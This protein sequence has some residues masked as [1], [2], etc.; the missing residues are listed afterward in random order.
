MIPWPSLPPT[1]SLVETVWTV[2][3]AVGTGFAAAGAGITASN[4]RA[5]RR[6]HGRASLRNPPNRLHVLITHQALRNEWFSV[7]ALTLALL[8]LTVFVSIGILA[9]VTPEPVRVELKME[10]L[11]V[12]LALVFGAMVGT[13]I[14]IVLTVGSVLNRRDRHRLTNAITGRLLSE[15]MARRKAA[16]MDAT[17]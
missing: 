10:D 5:A 6:A 13:A 3:T 2:T 17:P 11:A 4:L 14:A 15:Q 9:M 7:S 16:R 8:M 1:A 12:T